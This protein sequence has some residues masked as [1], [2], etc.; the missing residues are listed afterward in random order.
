MFTN[1]GY[2]ESTG[3]RTCRGMEEWM[4]NATSLGDES[5]RTEPLERG[6]RETTRGTTSRRRAA[7]SSVSWA[8]ASAGCVTALARLS[9]TTCSMSKKPG[10]WQS[11]GAIRG[12]VVTFDF[13]RR[14]LIARN[15]T[16]LTVKGS[17]VD[18]I[19]VYDARW[20]ENFKFESWIFEGFSFFSL[21]AGHCSNFGKFGG[22][23]IL[24]VIEGS[25]Y[26]YLKYIFT[27]WYFITW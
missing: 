17:V 15:I 13:A 21:L 18:H 16:R 26:S 9:T 24:F 11:R 22:Y 23:L 20:D 1:P 2:W 12:K 19:Y 7:S 25:Y 5:R 27:L 4:R 3:T 10:K 14:W 8:R 6:R